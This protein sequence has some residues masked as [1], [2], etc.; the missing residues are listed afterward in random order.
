VGQDTAA[1]DVDLVTNGDIVAEDRDVLEAGP[2]AD[3]AVPADNGALD[4]CVILDL[5]AGQQ[6]ASLQTNT[7]SNDDVLADNDVGSDA[8]VLANLGGGVDQDVA[9]VHKRLGG[10]AEQLGGLLGEGGEVQA[11]A[12]QEVLGLANVHPE[13]V[14]VKGVQLAILDD[15]GECLALDRRGS[16]LLDAVQDRGVQDVDTGVDPVANKLD[17]LLDKAVDARG[18]AGLVDDDTVLGGLLDLGD[19]NG[20]L[21]AVRLVEIGQLLEGELAGD[22]GV[23]DEEGGVILAQDVL[24]ELQGAGSAQG[25]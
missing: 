23:E 11:G 16:V 1:V 6:R 5:G 8:A 22:V 9:A 10:G 7:V 17:G 21:L 15:G 13:A 20:T 14:E 19:D 25:L 4:P 2:L 3:G 12:G 24:G 18:M